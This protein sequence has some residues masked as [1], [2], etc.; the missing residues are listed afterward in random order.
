ML[1]N[2]NTASCSCSHT[3]NSKGFIATTKKQKNKKTKNVDTFTLEKNEQ[4]N[5]YIFLS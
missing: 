5:R 1:R 4:K 2:T 3:Y